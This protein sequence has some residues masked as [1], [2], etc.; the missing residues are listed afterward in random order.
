MFC[1]GQKA[2]D[3]LV[4]RLSIKTVRNRSPAEARV[5]DVC[6]ASM[7]VGSAGS[8][9]DSRSADRCSGRPAGVRTEI[10]SAAQSPAEVRAGKADRPFDPGPIERRSCGGP[11]CTW[12]IEDGERYGL[13][14]PARVAGRTDRCHRQ[15]SRPN[16]RI[17]SLVRERQ[18][19]VD[20]AAL[21]SCFQRRAAI[22]TDIDLPGVAATKPGDQCGKPCF[23]EILRDTE[24]YLAVETVRGRGL[25]NRRRQIFWL[26]VGTW[27]SSPVILICE[28]FLQRFRFIGFNQRSTREALGFKVFL[29]RPCARDHVFGVDRNDGH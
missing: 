5:A 3:R 11:E 13:S 24:R 21:D 2:A 7:T 8:P 25:S 29:H 10:P 19:E 27:L 20:L 22:D 9:E 6:R 28:V 4:V 23:S 17:R 16:R 1:A 26:T 15:L 12:R 18:G 14:G